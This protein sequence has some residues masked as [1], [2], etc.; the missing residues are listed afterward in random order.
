M[1]FY[2]GVNKKKLVDDFEIMRKYRVVR[3]LCGLF[4][5]KCLSHKVGHP[6]K[7]HS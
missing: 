3:L 2:C 7:R 4:Q 1:C 5:S 6:N